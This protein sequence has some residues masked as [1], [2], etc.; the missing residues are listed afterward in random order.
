MALDLKPLVCAN[1]LKYCST[2]Y[3]QDLNMGACGLMF[4]TIGF[5]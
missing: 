2:S 4:K 1:V 3:S 5:I